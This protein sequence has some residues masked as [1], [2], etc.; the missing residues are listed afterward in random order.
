MPACAVPVFNQGPGCTD[1]VEVVSHR[2]DVIGRDRRR[3]GK[4]V[5]KRVDIG[6]GNGFPAHAVPVFNQGPGDGDALAIEVVSHCPGIMSRDRCY[7]GKKVAT[8][9]GVGAGDDLPGAAGQRG[10]FG[11]LSCEQQSSQ[12]DCKHAHIHALF[13]TIHGF[14]LTFLGLS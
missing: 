2:P 6:A 9:A 14:P 10:C 8:R 12:H 3:P 5:A 7:A 1:V 13:Q 11:H 4:E